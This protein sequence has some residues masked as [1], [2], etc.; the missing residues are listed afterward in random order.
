[1]HADWTDLAIALPT[2]VY[3]AFAFAFGAC[4]GSFIHV[5]AWRMPEGMSIV[6]PPSRCPVCGFRLRWYDNLPVIGWLR[7]RGRCAACKVAIPVRYLL[8]EVAVGLL[9]VAV[10]CILFLPQQGSFWFPVGQG[11]WRAQ[12]VVP[13]LPALF[14]VLWAVGSLIAMTLCDARTFLIPVAIPSWASVVAFACW[15]LAALVAR[16]L[17]DGAGAAFPMAMPS[18]TVSLAA[19]G[20]MVGLAVGQL[21][22]STGLLP[23]SFAD[24]DTYLADEDDTFAD[25]PHARREMIKEVAFLGPAVLFGGIGALVS[26]SVPAPAEVPL[27]LQ[28]LFAVCTGFVAAGALVW[29]VR[30]F[31]TTVLGTEAL[32]LGDVHLMAAAGAAFGWRAA[33]VGFFVAP[34][35]GLAWWLLN[36]VRHA[37]MRMPFGPSLAVGAI[38]AWLFRPALDGAVGGVLHVMSGL[39]GAARHDPATALWVALLM[40]GVSLVGAVAVR[41]GSGAAAALAILAMVA[42]VIAWIFGSPGVPAGGVGVGLAIAAG[43]LVAGV[44]V[45]PSLEPDS[46]PRT[47]TARVLRLLAFLVEILG[48]FLWTAGGGHSATEDSEGFP[49]A[50]P[51]QGP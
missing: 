6:S 34:F 13:A 29:V 49:G 30:L 39:A 19:A 5:V 14:A 16:P 51:L 27:A 24:Y 21:A 2:V 25:Y 37:P 45:Q 1:M 11:W 44:V 7:L 35:V 23:R 31:A 10:Y 40:V 47:V 33:V 28:A 3:V 38:V 43:C 42:A 26:R 32:G 12:G 36:L 48:A 4:A 46:G 22:L 9:F 41:R 50:A 17:A 15:P 8:S 20:A 18:W